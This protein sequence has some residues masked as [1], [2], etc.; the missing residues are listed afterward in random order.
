MAHEHITLR[1]GI[2]LA[3]IPL[4]VV[5]CAATPRGT[6]ASPAVQTATPK[7]KSGSPASDPS[8]T[9]HFML[10]YQAE[11]AQ[12]TDRAIQEYLQALKADPGAHA[13]KGRLAGLY[14]SL[15]DLSNA[16]RYAE[17]AVAGS[18]Q[19]AQMLSQMAGIFAGAGQPDRA[20]QLLDRAIEQEPGKADAYFSKGLLLMNQKRLTEAEQT[21]KQGIALSPD[22]PVGPYYLGRIQM[23]LSHVEDAIAS[24]ERAATVNASFEPT[25]IALASIYESRQERDKAIGVLRRYLQNVNPRNREVRNHLVRL[26]MNAK[27]YQGALTELDRMVTEDP[28]DLD[29][30]LRISLVYGELKEYQKAI[31]RLTPILAQR[32]AELKIRDYLGYLYEET[33]QYP[34]AL[35]TYRFNLQL[36]PSYFEGHLHLGVLLY[37]LKRYQESINHLAEAVKLNPKQPESYIVMGLG[38]LQSEQFEQA[39]QAFEEGI[40]HNPKNAD[41]HFNLGTAYDKLNRFDEVVRAMEMALK[42]DPHHADALNYLGY[43][44]AERGIK[45]DE[46]ISLTKQAVALKPN[47]GYY[48]DSLGWALFKSGKLDQALQ[49]IRRAVELAG[50]DPVIYE[51]LGEIHLKQHHMQEAREAL[52]RALELDPSNEKL[53]ERFRELGLGDPSSEERIQQAK[54]RIVEQKTL[55]HAAP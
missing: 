31:E 24:F 22:A 8:A 1:P 18:G 17:D 6:S 45:I 50:D 12:D 16:V 29:A 51:H 23:E 38:H 10:G 32:P 14:F 53:L 54:R 27:D 30:Q 39:A 55:E 15:G 42:L 20:V 48:V 46:A 13:V 40:R 28:T 37:R 2:A 25:Y 7:P 34:K 36:D 4:V 52:L 9:Y 11:L 33:K 44:Y 49:E 41:L 3:L 47:N 21:V 26:Y 35:D 5:A 19:D 43:S